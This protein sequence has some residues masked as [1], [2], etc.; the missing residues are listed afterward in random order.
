MCTLSSYS[1]SVISSDRM[2]FAKKR[3]LGSMSVS[4]GNVIGYRVIQYVYLV[5]MA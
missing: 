4:C 2:T 3:I 5:W 1:C